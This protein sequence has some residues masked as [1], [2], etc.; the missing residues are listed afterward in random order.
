MVNLLYEYANAMALVL[1]LEDRRLIEE[2]FETLQEII[3]RANFYAKEKLSNE[4]IC[5][6]VRK[7]SE[8]IANAKGKDELNQIRKMPRP[9][10]NG[11]K[12][13]PRSRYDSDEEELLLWSLITEIAPISHEG[14][15]RCLELFRNVLPEKSTLLFP[16]EQLDFG[17]NQ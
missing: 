14:M 5:K 4:V 2:K 10:F 17:K 11:E 13:I 15:E 16:E 1:T 7:K 12:V 9:Y 3:R 8:M 6:F